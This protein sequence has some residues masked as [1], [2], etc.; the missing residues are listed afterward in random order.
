M[1]PGFA[2]KLKHLV[3]DIV[4]HLALR[5]D[6]LSVEA[7]V[8]TSMVTLRIQC[9]AEDAPR[10]VGKAG[11]HH[12]A[13][14]RIARVIGARHDARV[15]IA[16]EA[17]QLPEELRAKTAWGFT[18]D[19]AWDRDG[20]KVLLRE[21]CRLVF[22]ETVEVHASD[23]DAQAKTVFTVWVDRR[24]PLELVLAMTNDLNTLFN[25]IGK[26]RG[27]LLAVDVAPKLD[28]DAAQPKSAAGRFAREV[29][30]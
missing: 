12:K 10:I 22:G 14:L 6:D 16:V 4:N 2:T 27:R 1:Q 18:P 24:E 25:V 19:P 5:A 30:R 11:A 28:A 15:E 21:I 9:H 20:I 29:E 17:P 7:D 26:R 23:D 8:L 3:G 13:L